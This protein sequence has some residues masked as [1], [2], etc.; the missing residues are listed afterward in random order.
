LRPT[1]RAPAAPARS[2]RTA[3][4]YLP[5]ASTWRRRRH[6][7]ATRDAGH[8]TT[9]RCADGLTLLSWPVP[10]HATTTTSLRSSHAWRYRSGAAGRATQSGRSC[11]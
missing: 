2:A 8:G 3:G 11:R 7:Q 5:A 10:R 9:R 4:T 1:T 6:K